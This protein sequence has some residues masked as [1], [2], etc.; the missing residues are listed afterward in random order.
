MAK[1]RVH[2]YEFGESG[3]KAGP[4]PVGAPLR[5]LARSIPVEAE[6]PCEAAAKAWLLEAERRRWRVIVKLGGS[7]RNIRGRSDLVC[8]LGRLQPLA[9][10]SG[11]AWLLSNRIETWLMAATPCG[12]AEASPRQL[13]QRGLEN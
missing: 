12:A 3:G 13:L 5:R 2:V 8:V 11:Y 10:W 1:Y 9:G 4:L 6:S 7:S